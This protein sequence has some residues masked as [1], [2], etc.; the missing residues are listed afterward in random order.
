MKVHSFTK[1]ITSILVLAS[2]IVAKAQDTNKGILYLVHEDQV[3]PEKAVMYEKAAKG[4]ADAMIKNTNGSIMYWVAS[5]DDF[6]YIYVIPVNN[7][8]GIDMVDNAFGQLSKAMGKDA[9]ESMMKNY[10]GTFSTHRDFMVRYR[11]DLSY[12]PDFPAENTFRHWDFY[13]I[14]P[15]KEKEAMEIAKEWKALFEKKKAPTGYRFNLGDI[16]L[17]PVFIVVQSAKNANDYY[18][19]SQEV[20]KLLGEEGEALMNKTWTVISRFDHKNGKIHPDLSCM[21]TTTSKK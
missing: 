13:Y 3:I 5:R 10:D 4:L 8:A 18:S 21:P 6:S 12:M 14:N 20:D 1:F 9:M 16:G 7:Y 17:E 19:K 11:A 15:E 2:C